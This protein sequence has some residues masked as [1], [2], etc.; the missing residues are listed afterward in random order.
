MAMTEGKGPL[1]DQP[2]SGPDQARPSRDGALAALRRWLVDQALLGG[3]VPTVAVGFAEGL[4]AAGVPLWR[5]HLA[6]SALDPE[7]ESIGLTWS[8]SGGR[9]REEYRH[10]SFEKISIGSPIYDAVIEFR[11]RGVGPDAGGHQNLVPMTRYRLE[12]GEGVERYPV[13][14]EFRAE[15][16]TDYLVFVMPF[17]ADGVVNP[18]PTGAVVTLATDR[19][20]GFS[21]EDVAAAV[22]LM[23]GFGGAVRIG[24]NLSA[25][26][27][28]LD[29]YLGRDVGRRILNGEIRRGSVETISAAIVFGDLRGFTALSDEIPREQLVAMLDDY[30]DCLVTPIEARGGQVLKFLGDGLLAT[31]ALEDSDPRLLCEDALAAAVEALARIEK[32]NEGRAA[33]G[34]PV[35]T[36]D[37]A[38][39]LG[40]VL[41]G[42]VGSDRRLDFTVI[43]PAVNEASRLEALCSPLAVPLIAS[44]KFVDAHGAAARFRSLGERQLR[45][46]RNPVEVFTLA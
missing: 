39:H 9:E 27:T 1:M 40:D 12:K 45:G 8:R 3:T 32:V 26:R 13:M 36:L 30:L 17:L 16:A 15:G 31:F 38:L 14:A 33:A 7:V 18:I 2:A 29:T 23:P 43:G 35:T 6:V 10:G 25:I 42:N 21:D 5:A 41:Y 28:A 46:V 4:L 22:E 19:P 34:L 24:S 37:V 44:G 11:A 20:G